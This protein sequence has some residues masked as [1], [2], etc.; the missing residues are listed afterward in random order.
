[1]FRIVQGSH[2]V[3]L[4]CDDVIVEEMLEMLSRRDIIQMTR[5]LVEMSVTSPEEIAATPGVIAY[6]MDALSG[7]GINLNEVMSC[8]TDTIFLVSE[9]DMMPA[10]KALNKCLT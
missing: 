1:L 8:H 5:G 6:L 4:I 7:D 10:F 9:S 3:T 2:G